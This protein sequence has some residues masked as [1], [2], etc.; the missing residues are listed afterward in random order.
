MYCSYIRSVSTSS[1]NCVKSTTN[2]YSCVSLLL[3]RQLR[4]LLTRTAD[5]LQ[6]EQE[7]IDDVEVELHRR[8]RVVF[9]AVLVLASSHD[10]LRVVR[11]ELNQ[12]KTT[13]S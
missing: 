6:Q 11:Q 1:E 4:P 8:R 12:N 9:L 2:H 7:D 5:E 10:H 3:D 13:T